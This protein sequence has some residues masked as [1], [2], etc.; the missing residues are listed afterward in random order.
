MMRVGRILAALAMALSFSFVAGTLV[1][2]GGCSGSSG[3]LGQAERDEAGEKVLQEK[4][5]EYMA[6]KAATKSQK[7]H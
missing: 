5:Q 1:S 2:T 7:K 3:T 4:M 6:K